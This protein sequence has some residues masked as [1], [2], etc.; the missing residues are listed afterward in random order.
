LVRGTGNNA[1][2]CILH[3]YA[4]PMRA[5]AHGFWPQHCQPETSC[6]WAQLLQERVCVACVTSLAVPHHM[7]HVWGCSSTDKLNDTLI[8]FLPCNDTLIRFLPCSCS[9]RPMED[10]GRAAFPQAHKDGRRA[11]GQ[12]EQAGFQAIM[13]VCWLWENSFVMYARR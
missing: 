9:T 11:R 3:P 7:A 13:C 10:G 2:P 5:H 8:R 6:V 12:L 4:C 1:R